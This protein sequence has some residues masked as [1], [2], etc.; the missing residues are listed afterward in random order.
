MVESIVKV[1]QCAADDMDFLAFSFNGKHSWDDFRI[2]RTIDGD[3]Y[4]E[5]FAPTLN[6]KTAEVPGGDGMYYFGTTHK[7][8]DFNISFAFDHLEEA[9]LREMKKWLNGKEMGDLW[10]SEAPYKVWTAKPSGN[11]AIKYIPFN[12]EDGQRV[13]KGEGTIQFTAYWPYA[14][15]PDF[16]QRETP[17]WSNIEV[18]DGYTFQE[19]DKIISKLYIYDS[20]E[21]PKDFSVWVYGADEGV[22]EFE[23]ESKDGYVEPNCRVKKFTFPN[24]LQNVKLYIVYEDETEL[25]EFYINNHQQLVSINTPYLFDGKLST[26][27]SDFSTSNQFIPTSQLLDTFTPGNNNGDLPTYFILKQDGFIP[28]GTVFTVGEA[29]ITTTSDCYNL[30][31][32]SKTGLIIAGNSAT[33]TDKKDKKPINVLGYTCAEIPVGG[34]TNISNNI[35]LK[36]HYWYY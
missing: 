26:S 18:N 29:E 6:D 36:Y 16:V 14:H 8:R 32:D 17:K 20:D 15:T 10:F 19:Q 5:N 22:G 9:Q 33:I 3:R 11:S 25:R 28:S 31:W 21:K 2:Y 34:V 23:R 1:P 12:D 30:E 35:E 24:I 13:Y 4:S 27:Y 7:Q